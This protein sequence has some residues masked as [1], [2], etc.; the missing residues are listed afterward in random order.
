MRGESQ[1]RLWRGAPGFSP[2]ESREP[3]VGGRGMGGFEGGQ[4]GW[5]A[6]ERGGGS[7]RE[8]ESEGREA[9]LSPAAQ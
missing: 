4:R 7:S 2:G 5:G 6:G 8:A 1:P 3:Y 9:I